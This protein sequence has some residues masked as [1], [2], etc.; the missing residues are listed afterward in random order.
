MARKPVFDTC[1]LCGECPCNCKK[2]A[3]KVVTKKV[4]AKAPEPEHNCGWCTAEEYAAG[5]PC[6]CRND[7]EPTPLPAPP[8]DVPARP[9]ADPRAAMR[10]HAGRSASI[11]PAQPP[12]P[13]V[14]KTNKIVH[15]VPQTSGDPVIDDAIRL[16]ASVMAPE[17]KSRWADLLWSE[18]AHSARAFQWRQRHKEVLG[19]LDQR[20]PA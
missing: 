11:P 13:V 5:M 2:P 3:K 6:A 8:V 7:L 17:E 20:H 16:L 10:A 1:M 18:R 19:G 9:K 15:Y 12:T 14:S 4:I